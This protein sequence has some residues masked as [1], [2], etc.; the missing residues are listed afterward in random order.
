MR[1]KNV[2]AFVAITLALVLAL[3]AACGGAAPQATSAPAPTAAPLA[4]AMAEEATQA[5]AAAT[6]SGGSAAATPVPQAAVTSPPA[7]A[8]SHTPTGDLR[9]AMATFGNERWIPGASAGAEDTAFHSILENLLTRNP[10]TGDNIGELAESWEVR[11]GGLTW[12]FRLREG[13][14]WH[15]GEGPVTAPDVQFSFERYAAE[16]SSNSRAGV[17]RKIGG[18]EIPDPQTIIVNFNEPEILFGGDLNSGIPGVQYIY[19]KNYVERVGDEVADVEAVASGPYR[20][21]NHDRGVRMDFEAVPDHWKLT[22]AFANM[23]FLKTVENSTRVAQLRA[24]SVD[25]IDIGVD[26]ANELRAA[27][28]QVKTVPGF[29]TVGIT[30]GGQWETK[31]TYDPTVPWAQPDKVRAYKVRR[32]LALAI[33]KETVVDVALG[34]L[35]RPMFPYPSTSRESLGLWPS[36]SQ[37]ATTPTRPA[38]CW[39][40]LDTRVAGSSPS[41]WCRGRDALSCR[42]WAKPWPPSGRP[43]W[44]AR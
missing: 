13:P 8:V 23:S 39:P 36:S 12:E 2:K 9:V 32:A 33:D 27:N 10:E 17:F 29:A 30:L 42:R 11:D 21:V 44:A 7:P 35:G 22:P 38:G 31:E 6:P 18:Y 40:R 43:T 24:G 19:P 14:Q 5:P 4:T 34:G 20:L 1:F 28:V 41:T 16:N 37:S 25:I 15:N 3:V 26:F